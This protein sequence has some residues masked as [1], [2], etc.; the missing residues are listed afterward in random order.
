MSDYEIVRADP[1][2]RRKRLFLTML[3]VGV[4][5]GMFALSF[6]VQSYLG[7]QLAQI[8][9][10]KPDEA[11]AALGRAWQLLDLL[12]AL[13]VTLPVLAAV[14]L[15]HMAF[16]I[17]RSGRFPYPGMWILRDRELL[18]GGL[19]RRRAIAALVVAAILLAGGLGA[20]W[21]MYGRVGQVFQQAHAR[22]L[23][24]KHYGGGGSQ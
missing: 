5:A 17:V 6:W 20:G 1:D 14:Y 10:G 21:Y 19:A 8:N 23:L 18:T 13:G 2:A 7:H 3:L 12:I 24:L 11:L 15:L 22:L 4:A 16:R 9:S